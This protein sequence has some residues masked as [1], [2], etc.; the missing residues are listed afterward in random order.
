MFTT[1]TPAGVAVAMPEPSR[2]YLK[3]G[4]VVR[5]T[6]ERIGTLENVVIREGA[7]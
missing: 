3:P 7:P 4:D 2:Y 5:A 6:I 1:G